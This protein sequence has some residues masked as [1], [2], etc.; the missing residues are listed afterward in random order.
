MD[1]LF[2][3]FTSFKRIM[4]IWVTRG[5][6]HLVVEAPNTGDQQSNNFILGYGLA[7][8]QGFSLVMLHSVLVRCSI[9]MGLALVQLPK[10]GLGAK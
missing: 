10:V 6:E 9:L 1:L 7:E 8:Q 2:I 3:P 4:L 5:S